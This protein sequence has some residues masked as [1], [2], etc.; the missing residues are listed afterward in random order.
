[1]LL[2]K[3]VLRQVLRQSNRWHI[4]IPCQ[5]PWTWSEPLCLE[6]W[7]LLKL[8]SREAVHWAPK[9]LPWVPG[10]ERVINIKKLKN[11]GIW[12]N[13]TRNGTGSGT[14]NNPARNNFKVWARY[15]SSHPKALES[16]QAGTQWTQI[17]IWKVVKA[18]GKVPI[19]I[20]FCCKAGASLCQIMMTK[21]WI[22]NL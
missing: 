20:A 10:R 15:E 14:C 9:Q 17:C 4:L 11:Y 12:T 8:F 18:V 13:K 7:D 5:T 3:T 22:E 6:R 21:T 19:L 2:L 1:M 16:N